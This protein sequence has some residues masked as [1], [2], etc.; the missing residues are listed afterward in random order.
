M[1]VSIQNEVKILRKITHPLINRFE[2][3]YEDPDVS[4]A[5]LVLEQAGEMNLTEFMDQ[6]LSN[7][8]KSR[9]DEDQIK[10]IM[11]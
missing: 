6:I 4:K 5:Y 8:K 3:Y 11:S 9:L 1:L 7:E 2:A 10:S